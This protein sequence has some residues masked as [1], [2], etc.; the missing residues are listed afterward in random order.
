MKSWR[1]GLVV[2]LLTG[3]LTACGGSSEAPSETAAHPPAPLHVGGPPPPAALAAAILRPTDLGPAWRYATDPP[4][5]TKPAAGRSASG[6][7]AEQI[8]IQ[9]ILVI[10]HWDGAHWMHD[11]DVFEYAV[12]Y[13][14]AADAHRVVR[15][16]ARPQ[17]CTPSP[18]DAGPSRRLA[19]MLDGHRVW[20]GKVTSPTVPVAAA[21][22]SGSTLIKMVIGG[23]ESTAPNALS[24]KDIVRAAI[25]RA[26][27]A[28]RYR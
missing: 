14:T 23:P 9:A 21:F 20:L 2:A 19:T 11:Q 17:E 22:V 12:R 13:A 16:S 24:V 7:P 25:R 10:Q 28:P 6:A 1:D 27:A 26:V 18:C 8:R 5:E 15:L 4:I 3:C